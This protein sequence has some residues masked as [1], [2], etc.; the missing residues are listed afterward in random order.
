MKFGIG[1]PLFLGGP[2]CQNQKI[3]IFRALVVGN[4][5]IMGLLGVLA[6]ACQ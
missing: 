4:V 1:L 6:S 5:T 2:W 3:V